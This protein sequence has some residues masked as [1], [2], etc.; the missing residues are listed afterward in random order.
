MI[1]KKILGDSVDEARE[2]ARRLYGEHVVV[3]ET[4]TG[5][6]KNEPSGVTVLVDKPVAER[7]VT[8]ATPP[9]NFRNVF[10]KRSDAV[11]MNKP[12]EPAPSAE[13]FMPEQP[14]PTRF[15]PSARQSS[16]LESLRRYATEN[17]TLRGKELNKSRPASERFNPDGRYVSSGEID[18]PEE[19]APTTSRFGRAAQAVEPAHT[20]AAPP[21][22]KPD[23]GYQKS[24]PESSDLPLAEPKG[25]D[26]SPLRSLSA[27]Y[28]QQS[29]REIAALH[30]RFDRLESLLDENLAAADIDLVAHPAF[31]QLV[32]SG[33]RPALVSRWFTGI[34]KKGTDPLNQP[35]KFMQELSGVV[36]KALDRQPADPASPIQVFMGASGAG[37][38]HLV[39]HLAVYAQKHGKNALVVSVKPEADPAWYTVLEPFC[40]DR[41]ITHYIS[42]QD[43]GILD[44]EGRVDEFD[45]VLV[46]TPAL[47]M[48]KEKAYRQ[49]WSMQQLWS[50]PAVEAQPDGP[51]TENIPRLDAELNYVVNAANGPSAMSYLSS[52]HHT[53]QPGAVSFTHLDEVQQWGPLIPFMEEMN[54]PCRYI[55]AGFSEETG[56][57]PYDA[58][59][60]A[61]NIL[62]D[63]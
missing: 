1:L 19:P 16:R 9:G 6:G 14:L 48:N 13:R 63:S 2:E 38:T 36:R 10:Y 30:K 59:E 11:R 21:E 32:Q 25:W 24:T 18:T 5:N 54:A 50:I 17:D 57:R 12:G 41:G 7:T 26:Q 20:N 27:G 52:L 23:S 15:D 33:I 22:Q 39:K 42:A 56:I 47:P 29:R 55:G 4:F 61:R 35:E 46:D 49:A 28:E 43:K 44:L 60:V 45:M 37:K 40:A 34:I 58:T 51:V 31:Q 53:L 3:L 8:D 62:Q